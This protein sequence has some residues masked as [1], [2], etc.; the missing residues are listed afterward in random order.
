[1]LR[2]L[3]RDQR[4]R[5][6]LAYGVDRVKCNE[7]AWRGLL[8]PQAATVSQ[9]GWHFADEDG[10][11]LFEE[12][13]RADADFDIDAGNRLL[14]EMGLT[15]RDEDGYRLR[16]DGKPI[17]M[18]MDVPSSNLNSQQNDIGLIIQ[19]GWEALGLKTSALYA[20]GCRIKF[21]AHA[22]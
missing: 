20:S 4:F 5:K 19:E 11:S 15:A 14:D 16:P 8:E 12:W 21:A 1:M 9:E 17:E 3:I 18:L 10:Q 13:K 6:A 7:I 2:K 22:R